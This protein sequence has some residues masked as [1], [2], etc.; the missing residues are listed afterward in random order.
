MREGIAEVA[1]AGGGARP[2]DGAGGGGHLRGGSLGALLSEVDAAQEGEGGS[3]GEVGLSCIVRRV[4]GEWGEVN[5]EWGFA[6][7][8]LWKA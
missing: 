5:G 1:Q 2:G 4:N 6:I 3:L 7:L 8:R